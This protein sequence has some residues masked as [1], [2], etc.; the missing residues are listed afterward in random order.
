MTAHNDPGAIIDAHQHFW[1]L[2]S[3]PY[4]WLQ[5]PEPI[6]FRY[7]DYSALRRNY[8]PAD[9]ERDIAPYRIVKSVHVEAEWDRAD[10]VAETRWLEDLAARE[11]RTVPS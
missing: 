2:D 8:L 6:P 3:N 4:P 1:D 9:Y 5:D 10:P 7:G 11:T